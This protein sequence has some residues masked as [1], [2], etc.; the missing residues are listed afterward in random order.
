V[1]HKLGKAKEF[2]KPNAFKEF[3][4]KFEIFNLDEKHI[5]RQSGSP[6]HTGN[7]SLSNLTWNTLRTQGSDMNINEYNSKNGVLEDL[8]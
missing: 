4:S 2:K 3:K 7:K 8:E 1:H 6:R 5:M